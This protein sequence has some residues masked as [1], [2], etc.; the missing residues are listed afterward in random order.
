MEPGFLLKAG[1]R[2]PQQGGPRPAGRPRPA[3]AAPVA[4]PV[5]AAVAPAGWEVAA[6]PGLGRAPELEEPPPPPPPPEVV[7]DSAP[8][9]LQAVEATTTSV[10]LQWAPVSCSVRSEAPLEAPL[11]VSLSYELQMQ[12]V[13]GWWS[14]PKPQADV[15]L[16][17]QPRFQACKARR[18]AR[19]VHPAR[20]MPLLSIP[21]CRWTTRAS[22]TP[23]AG[24]CST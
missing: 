16:Q 9:G 20:P 5:P 6:P 10:G 18:A 7:P 15:M 14:R 11:E 21:L 23:T 13:G 17:G 2:G 22:C 3:P 12:Q 4:A 24:A 8:G 1:G 19:L